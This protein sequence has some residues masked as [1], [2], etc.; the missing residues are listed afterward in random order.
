MEKVQKYN[1]TL[2]RAMHHFWCDECGEYLGATEEY[3]DGYYP[4]IGE[5]EINFNLNGWYECKR[6]LCSSCNRKFTNRIR[7]ALLELGFS[8]R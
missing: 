8:K 3:G 6:N 7:D 4:T 5:F 2:E 1:V